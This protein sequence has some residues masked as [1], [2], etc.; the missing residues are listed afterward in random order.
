MP[1]EWVGLPGQLRPEEMGKPVV[2]IEPNVIFAAS[3]PNP[4]DHFRCL[5]THSV[6]KRQHCFFDASSYNIMDYI[7]KK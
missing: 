3:N 4:F 6:S 5:D 2:A 7:N 1:P